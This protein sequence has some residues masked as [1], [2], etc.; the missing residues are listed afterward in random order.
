ML[1]A[2][3]IQNLDPTGFIAIFIYL[4]IF[5]GITLLYNTVLVSDEQQLESAISTHM[6]SLLLG[7]FA[8]LLAT[9]PPVPFCPSRSSQSTELSSLC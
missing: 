9:L 6:F 5:V 4:F 7:I 1:L 3:Q 2:S 8:H